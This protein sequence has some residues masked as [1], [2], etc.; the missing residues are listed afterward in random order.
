M[1]QQPM[2]RSLLAL[3]GLIAAIELVLSAADAGMIAD[4]TLRSRVLLPGAFWAQLL[5]GAAPLFPL[6]PA[7]MFVTHA[8]LHGSLLHMAI[9]LALGRF[10]ADRYGSLV[11]LPLFVFG[12]LAGGSVFGLISTAA[13]PMVGASGAVFGFMGVWIVWDWRRH[14]AHG[15]S[16]GPVLRRVLV[17]AGLNVVLYF[18]LQGMLA[19]EAHLGGFLAGLA[20]GAWLEGRVAR[21]ERET[22]AAAR[23]RRLEAED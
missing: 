13:Y 22:R 21:A 6:Q 18:G 23:R 5:H 11:V 12:A 9:L 3:A 8:L 14:K 10:V 2:P 1:P 16:T 20:G 15:V 17:L 7:T 4:P 19:W